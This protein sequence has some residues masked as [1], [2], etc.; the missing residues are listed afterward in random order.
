MRCPEI[1]LR[2]EKGES[3]NL[4]GTWLGDDNGYWQVFQQGN[5][6]WW[7]GYGHRT[8]VTVSGTIKPDFTISAVWAEVGYDPIPL[9]T[10]GIATLKID[11][12]KGSDPLRV[13]ALNSN[14]L[15]TSH[16]EVLGLQTT[17][18]TRVSNEPI[19]PPPTPNP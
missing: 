19:F 11:L 14:S 13:R 17:A 12:T 15:P 4:M 7:M 10:H 6:V 18:W 5:C 2:T 1:D 3:V 16:G 8:Q 9:N